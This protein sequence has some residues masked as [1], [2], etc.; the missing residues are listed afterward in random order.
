MKI[1]F[2][3]LKE[4]FLNTKTIS[5]LTVLNY[6]CQLKK[7]KNID[8]NNIYLIKEISQKF[9]PASFKNS[10]SA[11]IK[12]IR[13][14]ENHDEDLV[15]KYLDYSD[16]LTEQ[17][18]RNPNIK[19]EKEELKWTTMDKLKE[20]LNDYHLKIIK[21]N[22]FET[23]YENLNK[24]DK[25]IL[26]NYII[27][28]LYLLQPPRR[29]QDYSNMIIIDNEKPPRNDNYNYLIIKNGSVYQ[30]EFNKYKTA[31]TYGQQRINISN[32]LKIILN[33]YMKI[34]FNYQP[35]HLLSNNNKPFSPNILTKRIIEIFKTS[36]IKKAIS[37]N[38]IRHIY[39]SD[40]VG[41]DQIEIMKKREILAYNMGHSTK[42]QINYIKY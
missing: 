33:K 37:V 41:A 6:V 22:I 2:N 27:L 29:V 4:R 40:K 18:I 13:L 8:L 12:Y 17:D 16:E 39:I 35:I 20:V 38:I 25:K 19:T 21:N 42:T 30:F 34:I 31:K 11:I 36:R 10:I 26:N 1:D 14:D 32:E 7:F 28:S 15:D 24:S 9:K 23:L 3:N 5:E